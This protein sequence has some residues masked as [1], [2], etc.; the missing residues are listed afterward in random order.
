MKTINTFIGI[1]TVAVETRIE[2]LPYTAEQ[3]ISL[4]L[5]S[6]SLETILH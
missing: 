1:F 6:P 4:V 3:F 2:E 5:K